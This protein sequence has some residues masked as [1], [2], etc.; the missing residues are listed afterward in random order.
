MFISEETSIET[1][2]SVQKN[3]I[4]IKN[5]KCAHVY[6]YARTHIRRYKHIDS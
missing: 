3:L 6:T 1:N 4:E 5:L 2:T